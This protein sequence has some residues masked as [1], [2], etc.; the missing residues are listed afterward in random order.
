MNNFTIKG[1][2]GAAVSISQSRTF[3]CFDVILHKGTASHALTQ[4]PIMNLSDVKDE[5][6]V[7]LSKDLLE[8]RRK[9]RR[10]K[11]YMCNVQFMDLRK[12]EAIT[13]MENS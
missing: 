3:P 7:S 10:L 9:L 13:D 6:I 11:N 5:L 2:D 1:I 4:I 8:E 12:I